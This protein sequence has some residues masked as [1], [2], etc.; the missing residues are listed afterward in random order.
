MKI[1]S[2]KQAALLTALIGSLVAALLCGFMLLF[3]V[4]GISLW[5]M[6]AFVALVFVAVYF[7]ANWTI[8]RF[9]YQKIKVIYR[10]IQGR[11]SEAAVD[12][13]ALDDVQMEAE[14][15]AD[16]K[17]SEI[18][19]LEN[20]A[21]FRRDFIGNLAHE[22]RTPLFSIQGYLDTLIE[23]GIEDPKIN[24]EYLNRADKNLERL[25]VLVKELD[26]ISTIESG[27]GSMNSVK[28]DIVALCADVIALSELSAK[29]KKIKLEF[30]K[31]YDKSLMVIADRDRIQQVV[32][33]LVINAIHYGKPDGSCKIRFSDMPSNILVEVIDD[34]IGIS[35]KDIPRLFERFYRVDKSRSRN[36]GGTG[37][38]LSIVKHILELHGQAIN[39]Y[40]KKDVGTTFSFTLD[41]A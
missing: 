20:Q 22:L 23:G 8:E 30:A 2:A 5:L 21:Q 12:S 41:K 37:L 29:K 28:T 17:Q 26:E 35:E 3:A 24:Y 4:A 25:T 14:E 1:K 7:V 38:G 9:V 39:V 15:W 11:G 10:V 33:N 32:T 31:Q 19:A 18:Q 36:Q 27:R 40:S 34:G 13:P 6:A 16:K